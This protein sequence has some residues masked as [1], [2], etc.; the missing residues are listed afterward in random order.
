MKITMH[1]STIYEL[2]LQAAMAGGLP[3][4]VAGESGVD[5]SRSPQ[6]KFVAGC[7]AV[8]YWRTAIGGNSSGGEH[9]RS[10]SITEHPIKRGGEAQR[11]QFSLD[12]KPTLSLTRYA[13]WPT[14]QVAPAGPPTEAVLSDANAARH[15]AGEHGVAVCWWRCWCWR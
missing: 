12:M 6:S 7:R 2:G 13:S 5:A 1:E 15:V 14:Q 3:A 8:W 9:Q 10:H 4:L 11:G